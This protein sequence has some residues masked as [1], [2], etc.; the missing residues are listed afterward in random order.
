MVVLTYQDRSLIT[1]LMLMQLS[2]VMVLHNMA[3]AHGIPAET[4]MANLPQQAVLR[5]QREITAQ[6]LALV[7][8]SPRRSGASRW[9]GAKACIAPVI[10]CGPCSWP[11]RAAS[12]R[13]W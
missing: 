3:R 7:D 13:W 9:P 4:L 6:R 10:R 5:M 8:R 2:G 12:R 1:G 11:A